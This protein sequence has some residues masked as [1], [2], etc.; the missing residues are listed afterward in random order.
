MTNGFP[1][2]TLR[3]VQQCLLTI[4]LNV[5]MNVKH[6]FYFQ[7]LFQLILVSLNQHYL[8]LTLSMSIH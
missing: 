5:M 1:S 4:L 6:R 3:R 2:L 8:V 7:Q